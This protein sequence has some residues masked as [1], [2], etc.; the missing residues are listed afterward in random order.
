VDSQSPA[1]FT[2]TI[3]KLVRRLPERN[4]DVSQSL[5][6]FLMVRLERLARARLAG[7]RKR[8]C[9]EEDL[10][11][12]GIGD[13][14]IAGEKG[15][16]PRIQCREDVLKMLSR[17]LQQRAANLH[18][19]ENAEIRGGGQERGDSALGWGRDDS[20]PGGFDQ[21]TGGSPSP[22][23]RL[24]RAED[25]LEISAEIERALGDKTLF[26]VYTLWS[27]GR[28]KE[29]I[30]EEIDLSVSSVYRKLNLILQR[31]RESFPQARLPD[32]M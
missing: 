25:L 31:L 2:G 17:R 20:G 26:R 18:R 7:S 1:D 32:G 11:G 30:G 28:T 3:T 24:L 27:L 6:D 29:E 5:F 23:D 22:D 10:L 4:S 13:F 21:L 15:D 19:Y 16:L 9:D 14:L 8:V 12:E